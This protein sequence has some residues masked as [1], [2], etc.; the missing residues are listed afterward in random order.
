MKGLLSTL[1]I[2]IGFSF[3]SAQDLTINGNVQDS[4]NQM[5]IPGVNIIIKNTSQGAVTDFDG[6]FSIGN[7]PTGA[8]FSI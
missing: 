5:P 6:N 1:L 4:E 7:V 3:V 2:V 8:V